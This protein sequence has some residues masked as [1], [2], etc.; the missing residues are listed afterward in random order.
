MLI[1]LLI[2]TILILILKAKF[3]QY[4]DKRLDTNDELYDFLCELYEK[5]DIYQEYKSK[6]YKSKYVRDEITLKELE[7]TVTE[8]VEISKTLSKLSKEYEHLHKEIS[9]SD[10]SAKELILNKYKQLKNVCEF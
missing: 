5:N 6:L 7:I 8:L 9:R 4:I 10:M 2:C 1:L 3:Q